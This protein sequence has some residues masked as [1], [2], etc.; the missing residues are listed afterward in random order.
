MRI[1]KD[2]SK[3]VQSLLLRQKQNNWTLVLYNWWQVLG[4]AADLAKTL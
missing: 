1:K 4:V 2:Q 3:D